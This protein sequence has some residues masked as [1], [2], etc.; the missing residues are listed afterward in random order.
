MTRTFQAEKYGDEQNEEA[1][2]TLMKS[3]KSLTEF[4]TQK[5]FPLFL[6]LAFAAFWAV[7][8]STEDG[9]SLAI[10]LF[11]FQCQNMA[12]LCDDFISTIH[13]YVSAKV[14]L[15]VRKQCHA[16]K[17]NSKHDLNLCD[18]DN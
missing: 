1:S 8:F 4:R 2:S 7:I 14:V 13:F 11:L 15:P 9:S 5:A 6:H 10:T 12:S 17:Q 16:T 3:E 18:F